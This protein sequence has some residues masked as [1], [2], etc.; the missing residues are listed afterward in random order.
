MSRGIAVFLLT[1]SFLT[2]ANRTS[3]SDRIVVGSKIFTESYILGEIAAEVVEQ[4]SQLSVDRKMGIGSTGMLF[5]SLKSG[6]IDLYPDYSG[7]LAETILKNPNL[8]SLRDIREALAPLGLT[9]SNSLGFNNTYALAVRES[10]AEKFNLRT[11]SDLLKVPNPIRAAFSYEFMERQDGFSGM[12]RRY[13]LPFTPDSVARME[14]SLVYKAIDSG[15]VDLIEVYSTDAN[16]EKFKLRILTDDL[17]YFPSY[18]AVWVARSAFVAKNPAVWASLSKYENS[19]NENKMLEMNSEADFQKLS[20]PKI[21]AKF[22]GKPSSDETGPL[23]QIL[24]RTKEHFWL[25]SISVLFSIFVGIPLG[26]LAAKYRRAGQA[27]LLFSALVQTIPTLALLC[28]L[29][30][31]FGVGLRP[32][33]I[34]LCM[35]TLLPVILNTLTGIQSIDAKHLENAKAFGLSSWQILMKV[36][37]PLASPMIMAGLKTAT[38]VSIGTATLAAL[39]GAGGYGALIISG[40]SLNNMSTILMGAVPAAGMALIAHFLFEGLNSIVISKGIS[41]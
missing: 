40:L 9:I 3:A 2:L 41:K 38:I 30:P 15:A 14:H 20:F 6:D 36:T 37:F 31:L 21:A 5:E 27:I 19:I 7:T 35:Y 12:V 18:E 1:L 28:F 23:Q 25:V 29:I 8:R 17:H 10:Y 4:D 16:I 32:A 34:A 22:L 11:M 13:N 26:F 33:L 39:I 24:Q